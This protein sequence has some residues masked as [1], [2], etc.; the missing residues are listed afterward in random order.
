MQSALFS[1]QVLT[2]ENTGLSARDLHIVIQND[3]GYDGA[4]RLMG[5]CDVKVC[6][7]ACYQRGGYTGGTCLSDGTCKCVDTSKSGSGKLSPRSL[8]GVVPFQGLLLQHGLQAFTQR[9]RSHCCSSK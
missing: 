2:S 1:D 5:Q 6:S 8:S 7:E 4:M 9:V 3:A